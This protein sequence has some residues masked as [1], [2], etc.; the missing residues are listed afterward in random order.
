[1][2]AI[3]TQQLLAQPLL[4]SPFNNKELTEHVSASRPAGAAEA[5]L[6]S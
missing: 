2:P 4:T 6:P 3:A 5:Y 1:L